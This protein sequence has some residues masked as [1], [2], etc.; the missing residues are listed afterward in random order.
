MWMTLSCFTATAFKWQT[1]GRRLVYGKLAIHLVHL[2][3]A[4]VTL[5]A[6]TQWNLRASQDGSATGSTSAAG[7]TGG[8]WWRS[9][10]DVATLC[11]GLQTAAVLGNTYMLHHEWRQLRLTMREV[12]GRR[13]RR[14]KM[15][16]IAS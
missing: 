9:N 5:T 13:Q 6:S 4:A 3:L 14:R 10:V 8:D 11:D 15:R 1:Y 2:L 16:T 7:G 12:G